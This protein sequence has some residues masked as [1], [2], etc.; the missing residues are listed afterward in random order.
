MRK[1]NKYG[2]VCDVENCNKKIYALWFQML[3]RCYDSE[4]HKRSRGRTYADCE[5]C[6]KWKFLSCFMNDI[7]TLDGYVEWYNNAGYCLDKDVKLPENKVYSK[8]TCSF[9]PR[10]ENIRDISRR[11]P[12]VWKAAAESR[13]TKYKLE[14]DGVTLIFDS[15]S[16]AC[17][18]LG[19]SKC[20]VSSCA[21]RGCLCKGYKVSPV[22]PKKKAW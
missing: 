5:V 14:A 1:P 6:D 10:S 3:R 12:N 7:K 22:K 20:S 13:K 9:V 17:K 18:F 8:E 16:E 21:R 2:G 4:Q 15:E 19:V 11:N